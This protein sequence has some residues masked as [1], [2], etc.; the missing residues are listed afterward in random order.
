M[1][2]IFEKPKGQFGKGDTNGVFRYN[3]VENRQE[4]SWIKYEDG[5]YEPVRNDGNLG[6]K[7]NA[8]YRT[9]DWWQ[10]DK[11]AHWKPEDE[12]AGFSWSHTTG[13]K[14]DLADQKTGQ[15]LVE[16]RP[17]ISKEK[18]YHQPGKRKSPWTFGQDK[19]KEPS[20]LG[21]L[22]GQNE[23]VRQE[24]VS[25]QPQGEEE[26]AAQENHTQPTTSIRHAREAEKIA[27]NSE[28][29]GKLAGAD[30]DEKYLKKGG[31]DRQKEW[32]PTQTVSE[33]KR[34][35]GSEA[36][37]QDVERGD[38]DDN[39]YKCNLFVFEMAR[40]S[41]AEIPLM[42]RSRNPLSDDRYP[43]VAADWRNPETEIEGWVVVKKPEPGDIVSDGDHM[44]IVS[45]DNTTISA[46]ST[47]NKVV[48]NDFGFSGDPKK[49]TY[50]RYVG[51]TRPY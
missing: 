33:A 8:D 45:G 41:G 35:V 18:G 2:N 7:K 16:K 28:Q 13:S 22:F 39:D 50:R 27:A 10:V 6:R 51:K 14:D 44:G 38:F 12:G 21:V 48:E 36:W 40:N 49:V 46:S 25:M 1:K 17:E 15:P 30:N 29:S 9:F 43:P 31:A 47:E 11:P 34:H 42:H 37:R 3:P 19:A 23:M 4:R 5:V 24:S 26:Q 20:P 32:T